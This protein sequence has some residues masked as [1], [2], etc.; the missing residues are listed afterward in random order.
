M[1]YLVGLGMWDE[2][3]ISLK[4]VDVCKKADFVY[5]ETYTANWGGDLNRL[6]NIIGHD[7]TLLKRE[8]LEE[9]V[10][11]VIKNAKDKDIVILVPGDPLV[12]TTHISI[13]MDAIE[14]GIPYSIIHSSSIYSAISECGL[15]V[16]NFGRTATV[17]SYSEKYKP[18]SFYEIIKENRDRGLHTLMLL[19]IKMTVQEGLSTLMEI[20]KD[21]M[22]GAIS[23][24]D[25]IVVASMLGSRKQDIR[26]GKVGEFEKESFPSPAVIIIPGKPHFIEE[27][28]LEKRFS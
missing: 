9:G 28:F 25:K 23:P 10:K 7:I 13:I 20:E 24:D 26:Y 27:E 22:L 4:G 12:A 21:K 17:V 5:A 15:N 11:N 8:S 3:D 14:M 16:Y 18:V 2:K 1:L 19:D 6:E